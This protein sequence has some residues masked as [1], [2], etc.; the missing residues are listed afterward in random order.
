MVVVLCFHRQLVFDFI[1]KLSQ[2]RNQRP[3]LFPISIARS[4][5]RP[6]EAAVNYSRFRLYGLRIYGL[7]GYMVN[8]WMVPTGITVSEFLVL[9]GLFA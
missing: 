2:A 5:V 8:F 4:I 6:L 7:F 9:Y 1:V 3:T